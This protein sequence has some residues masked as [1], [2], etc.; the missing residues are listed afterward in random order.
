LRPVDPAAALANMFGTSSDGWA[1]GSEPAPSEDAPAITYASGPFQPRVVTES[2]SEL[3]SGAS[4]RAALT[5]SPWAWAS[6]GGVVVAV[7]FSI[8]FFVSRPRPAPALARVAAP[9]AMAGGGES[10]AVAAPNGDAA[11]GASVVAPAAVE[12]IDLLRHVDVKRDT[13]GGAW[14]MKNGALISDASHRAAVGIRYPVPREYDFRVQF[15]QMDGDNCVVQMFTTRNPAALVLGGWKRTISGFQQIDGVS[16]DKNPTGVPGL[17]WDN[18][19]THTSV[20]RVRANRIEAWLDGRL[21][22]S[23]VTDGSNLSN[24]SWPIK[25][26]PL[27]VGSQLSSTI[28]H[29]VEL[30]PAD[31][32]VVTR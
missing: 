15:T 30:I 14:R 12:P 29:K 2:E 7:T 23:Y 6:L 20:V 13:I 9:V 10:Q 19:R 32:S 17:R 8:V 27:G 28:F 18:G 3:L 11:R 26:Y 31:D 1:P 22:T 16:A 25:D 4:A 21:L 5:A 24:K